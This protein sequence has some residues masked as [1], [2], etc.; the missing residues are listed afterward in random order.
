MDVF[1]LR[2]Q[3]VEEYGAFVRSF[4]T[5]RDPKIEKLVEGELADGRTPRSPR[6]C[7]GG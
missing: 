2:Q 6:R 4:L 7:G 1:Q 3:V 5:I